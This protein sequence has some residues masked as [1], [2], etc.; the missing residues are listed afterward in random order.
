[1]HDRSC[2]RLFAFAR[3]VEDLVRGFAGGA[4]LGGADLVVDERR[5][6][7][8]DL[9]AG[10]LMRAV[11]GPERSGSPGDLRRVVEWLR[12]RLS[13]PGEAELRGA[14][15][16]WLMRLAG[17]LA[18]GGEAAGAAAARTL[19]EARVTPEE[20][21]AQWPKQWCREGHEQGLEQGREEGPFGR[22]A[23]GGATT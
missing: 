20:R 14:F 21:V 8:D 15:V 10:S 12:G 16:D 6:E 22:F 19:E 11:V 5:A 2:K 7:E 18:P 13:A 23:P 9:P 1:M 17:R 4:W 3:T